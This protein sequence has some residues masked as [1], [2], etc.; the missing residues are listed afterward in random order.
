[1]SLKQSIVV[2]SRFSVPLGHGQGSRGGTPGEFVLRYMARGTAVENIT[3]TRLHEH[4]S[5]MERFSVREDAVKT[6]DNI[7]AIKHKM[8]KA[9]RK[10][11]IAF[12]DGDVALSDEKLRDLSK[13]M[14]RQFESGK[15]AIETILSFT[16][17]YLRENGILDPDF[18]H[19]K[20]GD[21]FGHI[22]Q[23][24]L[25]MAIMNGVERMGHNYDDL[26]YVGVIQVDTNQVHCHLAMMDYGYG[27]RAK[28][29]TQ[30]GKLTAVDMKNLRRGLDSFLDQKQS[31]KMMSSSV[32]YDRRNALCYIKR[33]THQTMAQQGVPQFLLACLPEN[34][35]YWSAN[36][37]RKEMRKPNAI[38]REFVMDVLQPTAQ[39][40]S[41]M[42]QMA[43]KSIE[44]YADTRV[45]R[46]GLSEDERMKLIRN[47]EE[48]LV[49]ECM[50]GV[51][52]VLKRIPKS[53]M[54]VRTPMMEAMSMDY[55]SMATQAVNDP[56]ME[57][58]FRLR[59]YA[60]R[61]KVHRKNYHKFKDEYEAYENTPEKT[62]ESKALGE[63]LALERDY[64]RMLMVKYQYFLTFLP[65][66][67]DIQ[68]EFDAVM[69]EQNRLERMYQ[70]GNDPAFQRML[71][72]EANRYGMQVYGIGRGA[73]I[74]SLPSV[75]ERRVE[76]QQ[77]QYAKSVRD[78]RE[79]LQDYGLDFDGHGVTKQ[80]V[81]AFDD[82]KA[83]DLHHL[84]YDFP[85]DVMI[86]KVNIDRFVDM[87]NRRYES[88][89]KAREY[90]ELTGQGAAVE[91]LMPTDVLTMKEFADGL[92]ENQKLKSVRTGSMLEHNGSTVHLGT[93]YTVDMKAA[94]RSTVETTR[95]FEYD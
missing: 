91:D 34:R 6:E 92:S 70:M 65:P 14:Q 59:S 88:F 71:P 27:N 23:L 13:E 55:E 10:G 35:N 58:G 1:M 15:T 46:E 12:G 54:T 19:E 37:N 85:T 8:R 90:L 62:E 86:S 21:Y 50:N 44:Q 17:D 60:S 64:Q 7:P 74:K 18:V 77:D 11:G 79:R 32:M 72:N 25:R 73:M 16:E 29:G 57:F 5:V 40:A 33:F 39:S 84:G 24:K 22:D 82:V 45:K 81:Y 80:K 47:G 30:R 75:W 3:P 26:H 56:M 4:D 94:V 53:E 38:V 87:A 78:F 61:L 93:D 48:R 66:D 83:L 52:S 95:T 9:Q 43:H 51:Y 31:V 49:R 20:R 28:D 36:S 89:L 76:L 2:K 41:P 69:A 68:T 42:Y 63:H 67:E